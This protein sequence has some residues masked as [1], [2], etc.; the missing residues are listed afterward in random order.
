[1]KPKQIQPDGSQVFHVQLS[2]F[3]IK[4]IIDEGAFGKVFQVIN[5]NTG[6][7]LALKRLNKDVLI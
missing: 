6:Q 5:T 7:E 2:D 4:S 1:V 3:K